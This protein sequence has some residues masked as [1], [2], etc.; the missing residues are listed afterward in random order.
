MAQRRP[1]R[2]L[3]EVRPRR[4][5]LHRHRR[6]LRHR[7]RAADRPGP[8]EHLRQDAAHRRRST[9]R[10]ARATAIPKDN[11]FVEHEGRPARDLGLRP[12]AALA[13]Q[14]RPQDRRPVGRRGRPGSVGDGLQDREG[15]QLRLV[16]SGRQR[17]PSAPNARRARRRSSSRSSSIR[18]PISARSPA[19]S[20]ITASGC[21][22]CRGSTSTAISTRAAFGR[23]AGMVRSKPT[24]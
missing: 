19:A 2:R 12:A 24:Q 20:S 13:V 23:S 14:L 11:P 1:Q 22:S 3:P 21:R 4:H 17:I 7:R 15:R 18:T 16:A 6:R 5:A 10:P 8:V 9:R